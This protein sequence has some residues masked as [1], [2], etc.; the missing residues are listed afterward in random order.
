MESSYSL[1]KWQL[2]SKVLRIGHLGQVFIDRHKICDG[3]VAWVRTIHW[4]EFKFSL[5]H[6]V[7]KKE[8]F[9]CPTHFGLSISGQK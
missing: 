9:S 5:L 8:L 3:L 6:K 2:F 1:A 7:V 4:W